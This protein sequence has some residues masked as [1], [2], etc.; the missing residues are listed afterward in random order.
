LCLNTIR[1]VKDVFC[2][3]RRID[4][5]SVPDLKSRVCEKNF[6]SKGLLIRRQNPIGQLQRAYVAHGGIEVLASGFV[7]CP[8]CRGTT[9][10]ICFLKKKPIEKFSN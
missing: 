6:S 5:R 3:G 7:D 2:L 9:I 8:E 10:C 4:N 1:A